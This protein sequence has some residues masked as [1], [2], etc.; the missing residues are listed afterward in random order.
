[1]GLGFF[2]YNELRATQKLVFKTRAALEYLLPAAEK[3]FYLQRKNPADFARFNT[4]NPQNCN[5]DLAFLQQQ[6]INTLFPSVCNTIVFPGFIFKFS[7]ALEGQMTPAWKLMMGYD[8]WWQQK[9]KLGSITCSMLCKDQLE[10]TIA[11]RPTAFQN[12]IFGG[13]SYAKKGKRY[14]WCLSLLGDRTFIS[15]GIG[16]DF[17]IIGRFEFL[18]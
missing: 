11:I 7:G 18:F 17:S 5:E 14:D 12:K 6:L 13:V 16:K 10:T 8:L 2:A 1:V 4:D 15:S 3:R 9:E